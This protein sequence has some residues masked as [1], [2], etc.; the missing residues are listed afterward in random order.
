M[1]ERF[2]SRGRSVF[3]FSWKLGI[4]VVLLS[5]SLSAC[6]INL[7]K[8]CTGENVSCGNVGSTVFSP[9]S[10][11]QAI[12]VATANT[13]QKNKPLA[14][15]PL[16]SQD[17]NHWAEDDNCYF[18]YGG[19]FVTYSGSSDGTYTCDSA[20]LYYRDVA[21]QMDV[22]LISGNSAGIMFRAT[23]GMSEFYEFMI[24]YGSFALG[25]FGSNNT[26]T[27]LFPPTQ[28]NAVHGWGG[29]NRLLVISEGNDF[30]LFIN[31][32]FVG[33]THDDT[34]TAGYVGVSLAY[35]P[36]GQAIFSNLV[37]YPV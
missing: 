30:R 32:T 2:F 35:N 13:I 34:L 8:S 19:Y 4:L 28:S 14:S 20:K 10:T 6:G 37:I 18:R 3:L 21:I 27:V 9:D 23:P 33:E 22:T 25:L 5:T 7:N 26:S 15:D 29:K 12:A 1:A 17:S 31:G 11:A 16:N 24:G 36:S